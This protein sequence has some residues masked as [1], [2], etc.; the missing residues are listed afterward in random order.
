MT[1]FVTFT[2][3]GLALGSIYAIA[4]AGLVVTC[5]TSGIFNFAHGAIAMFAAFLYWQLRWDDGWGGHWPA[6]LARQ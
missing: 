1:D 2:I 6:P 5:T 4:A 3:L